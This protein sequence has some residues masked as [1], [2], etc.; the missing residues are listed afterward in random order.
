M[1]ETGTCSVTA[2]VAAKT[3]LEISKVTGFGESDKL[4]EH[5]RMKSFD[6]EFGQLDLSAINEQP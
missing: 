4:F 1:N 6:V 5:P 2:T 3:E